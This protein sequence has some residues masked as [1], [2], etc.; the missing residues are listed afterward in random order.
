MEI[1]VLF[2]ESML[3]EAKSLGPHVSWTKPEVQTFVGLLGD[4]VESVHAYGEEVE[5]LESFTYLGSL[6]TLQ[7][8]II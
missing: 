6:V 4:Q 1:L 5:I 7:G 2:F 3:E 8:R